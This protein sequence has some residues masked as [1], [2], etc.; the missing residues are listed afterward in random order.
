[1]KRA[2]VILIAPVFLL[3]VAV[4]AAL[5]WAGASS[6][7][8]STERVSV[9]TVAGRSFVPAI[10]ADGQHVAFMSWFDDSPH[11]RVVAYDRD[12]GETELISVSIDGSPANGDSTRPAISAD[13]RYVAFVSWASN[14]VPNDNNNS[15]DTNNDNIFTENCPD[16]FIRDRLAGVTEVVSVST[17]G[18]LGNG[19]SAGFWL[20]DA[21]SLSIS[22]DGRYVAFASMASNLVAG[23]TNG[24]ADILVR[25]RQT[26]STE[27]ASVSRE[28]GQAQYGGQ[29]PA[30]SADGA[31]VAFTSLSGDLVEGDTNNK[32]DVFVRDLRART[33]ERVSDNWNGCDS[34]SLSGDGRWVL[35]RGSYNLRPALYLHDRLTRG[36]YRI[37]GAREPYEPRLSLDGRFV[38]FSSHEALVP[39]DTNGAT[40]VFVYDRITAAIERVSVASSGTEGNGPSQSPSIGSEGRFVAFSSDASNLVPDDTDGGRDIFVRDRCPDGSCGGATPMPTPV[41]DPAASSVQAEPTSVPA[42]GTSVS[43]ITVTVRDAAGNPIA[44]KT[45]EVSSSR[46]AWD[47]IIEPGELTDSQG[48]ATAEVSSLHSGEAV[49]SAEVEGDWVTITQTATV[50]FARVPI[51]VAIGDSVSTGCSVESNPDGHADCLPPAGVVG[52]PDLVLAL[53]R[54][55]VDPNFVLIRRTFWGDTADDLRSFMPE[56]V[57]FKPDM[58]T[59]TLGAN[60]F[61]FGDWQYWK[62]CLDSP[63]ACKAAIIAHA[64]ELKEDFLSTQDTDPADGHPDGILRILKEQSPSS[65]VFMTGYY[66]PADRKSC[67]DIYDFGD[68][69]LFNG[70]RDGLEDAIEESAKETG[71]KYVAVHPDFKKHGIMSA[72]PWL[73]G[74]VCTLEAAI[75]RCSWDVSACDPHPNQS[76]QNAL[77]LAVWKAAKAVLRP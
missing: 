23:D 77:A 72:D 22:G 71:Y 52:Y 38:A 46:G 26:G 50:Q 9:G 18:E 42:N 64:N 51:Y 61:R 41:A 2:R 44:G 59:I 5:P 25:D 45:V 28:N 73:Y 55:N 39:D 43:H 8:G 6:T 17:E 37:E 16:V 63:S 27:R 12:T 15:C 67:D 33:T 68:G 14:L 47:R 30:I 36:T 34:P 49:F 21:N 70:S 54:A 74:T 53:L 66:N 48:R 31:F 29:Q 65:K 57:S 62:P 24:A 13:G 75:G 10:S 60:D 3:L 35:S 1:M 58:V 56:L 69:L 20:N 4:I 11:E 40:D 7:T 32:T 19:A 76:G